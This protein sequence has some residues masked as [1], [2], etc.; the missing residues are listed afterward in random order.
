M[1]GELRPRAG[2]RRA[3]GQAGG[4]GPLAA[5]RPAA[6]GRWLGRRPLTRAAPASLRAASCSCGLQP[7]RR[8]RSS[9]TSW[10]GPGTAGIS[11]TTGTPSRSASQPC[12]RK[13]REG[14]GGEGGK[15]FSL[16]PSF[17]LREARAV[18]DLS[19][20]GR[21]ARAGTRAELRLCAELRLRNSASMG[22]SS[23]AGTR[24]ELRSR[25]RAECI[26]TR[27]RGRKKRG[28]EG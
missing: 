24:E 1:Q 10:I 28:A 16:P 13:K 11:S 14:G 8:P 20:M 27:A 2:I 12:R 9:R 6:A 25:P 15:S 23:R 7:R 17:G 19:C 26:G 18:A 4:R 22:R 3:A 21:R 5:G